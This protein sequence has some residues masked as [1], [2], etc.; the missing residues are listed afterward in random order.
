[1]ENLTKKKHISKAV[2]FSESDEAQPEKARGWVKWDGKRSDLFQLKQ[3]ARQRETSSGKL[4][5]ISLFGVTDIV[6]K[7]TTAD[8]TLGK[9]AVFQEKFADDVV[10]K[11]SG[12]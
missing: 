7:G 6:L 10:Y 9:N 11:R 1:M 4:F 3:G 2:Q 8:V 5:H 12:I